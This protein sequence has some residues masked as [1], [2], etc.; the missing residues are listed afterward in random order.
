[1]QQFIQWGNLSP[2]QQAAQRAA[3]QRLLE[4]H[5][6]LKKLNEA[7]QLSSA[8]VAAPGGTTPPLWLTVTDTA[9]LYPIQD[10]NTAAAAT[11]IEF[12]RIDNRFIFNTLADLDTFYYEVWQQT[13]LSQ[14]TGNT[15]YTMG[16]GT[17]LTGSFDE[18]FLDLAN[19]TRIVVW[20]LMTMTTSQSAVLVG[21]NAPDGT[22][23][24]GSV[25][26]DLNADGTPGT[27]QETTSGNIDPLRFVR[28]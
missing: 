19:G 8:V 5:Y 6:L 2:D 25:Y 16:V 4:E 3:Q 24:Y 20:Q 14:P 13:A 21:G 12:T 10:I 15:G 1:M 27:I 11:E 28:R 17:G 9:Y 23:G 26:T 22:V 7:R 18:L